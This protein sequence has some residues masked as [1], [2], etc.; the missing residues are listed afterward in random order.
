M[1]GALKHLSFPYSGCLLLI[2]KLFKYLTIQN[3]DPNDSFTGFVN[4]FHLLLVILQI[5]KGVMPRS[6]CG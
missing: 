1:V 4:V 3:S 6:S 2:Y 5:I